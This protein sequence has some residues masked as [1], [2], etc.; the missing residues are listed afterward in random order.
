MRRNRFVIS[1]IL[2]TAFTILQSTILKKFSLNGAVPDFALIVLVF[3]ANST[4]AVK[5]QGLGF[6]GGFIQDFI[7]S[8]P[9]GF[10]ALIRT[11]IGFLY[12]K[13]KGFLYLDSILLPV[14]FVV[15]GTVLKELFSMVAAAALIPDMNLPFFDSA[16]LVEIGLNAFFSP[17]IFALIKALKIYR[18]NEKEQY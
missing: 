12:G 7:S 4:G 15:V 10:N 14:I 2:I 18:P 16:F 1:L 17:F 5:G 3:T 8:G 9:L 11:L 13:L 6:I